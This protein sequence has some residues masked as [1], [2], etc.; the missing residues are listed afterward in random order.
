MPRKRLSLG[1]RRPLSCPAL[2]SRQASIALLGRCRATKR[3]G[4]GTVPVPP[5]AEFTMSNSGRLSSVSLPAYTRRF[6]SWILAPRCDPA[7]FAV[8]VLWGVLLFS[9]RSSQRVVKPLSRISCSSCKDSFCF[10]AIAAFSQ[11][12]P[13]RHFHLLFRTSKSPAL[14]DTDRS[15]G[16]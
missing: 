9:A 7:P 1:C 16:L 3:I 5:W 12:Q 13:P 8:R 10:P 4:C 6:R 15:A 2:S 14:A 11:Y